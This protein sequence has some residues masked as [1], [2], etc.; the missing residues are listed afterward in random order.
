MKKMYNDNMFMDGINI[1]IKFTVEIKYPHPRH[2]V[3]LTH[4]VNE[5]N[6]TSTIT[7]SIPKLDLAKELEAVLIV[8]FNGKV[9][10]SRKR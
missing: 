1:A 8:L 3:G 5:V 9:Q 10:R 2:F 7:L 6:H 4:R